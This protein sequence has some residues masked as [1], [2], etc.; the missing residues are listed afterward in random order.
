MLHP[1][2]MTN[3]RPKRRGFYKWEAI[4]KSTF[5]WKKNFCYFSKKNWFTKEPDGRDLRLGLLLGED[6]VRIFGDIQLWAWPVPFFWS[7]Q[8]WKIF[9]TP[10]WSWT[11]RNCSRHSY[12]FNE[13]LDA[14]DN[15][16]LVSHDSRVWYGKL[17]DNSQVK[18]APLCAIGNFLKS[19]KFPLKGVPFILKM[20]CFGY[21]WQ[22]S[23][24]DWIWP[25]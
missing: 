4:E 17:L 8:R 15:D 18:H 20:C 13:N 1:C 2:R 9:L 6:T 22:V 7:T 14:T 23:S 12:F 3:L 24:V 10:Y 11:L 19:V 25:L 21:L 5:F 16:L